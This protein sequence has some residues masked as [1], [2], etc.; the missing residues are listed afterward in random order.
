MVITRD[1]FWHEYLYVFL[2]PLPFSLSLSPPLNRPTRK[3]YQESAK[4]SASVFHPRTMAGLLRQRAGSRQKWGPRGPWSESRRLGLVERQGQVS[5]HHQH[6]D[7]ERRL[8]SRAS[9]IDTSCSYNKRSLPQFPPPSP[10]LQQPLDDLLDEPRQTR[11]PS[12]MDS[13][14]MRTSRSTTGVVEDGMP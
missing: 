13:A 1:L 2:F 8:L 10:Q 6:R 11:L 4:E 3:A 7:H 9:L 5:H 14:L 12:S